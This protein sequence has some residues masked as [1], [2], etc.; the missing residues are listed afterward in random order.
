MNRFFNSLCLSV[1]IFA[2]SACSPN[3]E[4]N[5]FNSASQPELSPQ[6]AG[7]PTE[8]GFLQ[9]VNE[10]GQAM[11]GASVLVGQ[12]PGAP[13]EDNTYVTDA[14]GYFPISTKWQSAL[15]VTVKAPGSILTTHLGTLPLAGKL[16]VSIQDGQQKL[17]VRGETTN[18]GD[19]RRDGKVDFGFVMPALSHRQ[20]LNFDVSAIISPENDIIRILNRDF[21]IPSNLTLP[22][23]TESYVFPITFNKPAYRVYTREPGIKRLI[24]SHGQFPLQRVINEIRNGKSIF[25]VINYFTFIGGGM[26]DVQ[27]GDNG[28][29]QNIPVNEFRYTNKIA[30]TAP[31]IPAG[32]EMLTLALSNQSGHMYPTDLKRFS[33]GERLEMTIPGQRET[34][35]M[36]SL[37]T[38]QPPPSNFVPAPM[39]L[40]LE[41]AFKPFGF[42]ELLTATTQDEG[43][44]QLSFVFQSVGSLQVPQFLAPIAKPVIAQDKIVLTPPPTVPNIEVIGTIVTLSEV[45]TINN[46]GQVSTERK[47]RLWELFS[48]GW[49]SEVKLPKNDFERDPKKQYRWEVLYMGSLQGAVPPSKSNLLENITHV[50]RNALDF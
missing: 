28:A 3:S 33:S 18:F 11:A 6:L 34:Q 39:E 20:L 10:N 5:I 31:N 42:R 13:F 49:V 8:S 14:N 47:T 1:F 2:F 24:A 30:F 4:I 22:E 9:V 27:V 21:A 38:N 44:A 25:E 15:P 32:K 37:L 35:Y 46:G 48:A 29:T 12:A 43:M 50:T 36:L 7:T 26:R 45:E 40:P 16:E 19:L 23:Q 17:E 41:F